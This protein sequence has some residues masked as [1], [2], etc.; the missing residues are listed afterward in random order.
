MM[1]TWALVYLGAGTAVYG[2][3]RLLERLEVGLLVLPDVEEEDP[4]RR[5]I[6][7]LAEEIRAFST[8]RRMFSSAAA[9]PPSLT[10]KAAVG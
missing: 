5:E 4:L 1:L 7:A 9:L 2:F 10:V 3:M 8:R 6:T